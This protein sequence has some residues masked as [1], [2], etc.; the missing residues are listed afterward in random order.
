MDREAR[1][2]TLACA[3]LY[4]WDL[5]A[6]KLKKSKN[7]DILIYAVRKE[8]EGLQTDIMTASISRIPV[9]IARWLPASEATNLFFLSRCIRNFREPVA[10]TVV[11]HDPQETMKYLVEKYGPRKSRLASLVAKVRRGEEP[12][13]AYTDVEI[14]REC[15]NSHE[16]NWLK[17][18]LALWSREDV[19][20]AVIGDWELRQRMLIDKLRA[21]CPL[22]WITVISEDDMY[23]AHAQDG[24]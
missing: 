8:K 23:V 2:L 9:W 11:V 22:Q 3:S 18:S 15:F 5:L 20:Q 24:F 14:L 12:T 13:T 7:E 17:T 19:P 21:E 1:R 4:M 6:K 10:L 16:N